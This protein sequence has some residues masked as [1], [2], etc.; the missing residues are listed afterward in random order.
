MCTLDNHVKL[1]TEVLLKANSV[2]VPLLVW[3][4]LDKYTNK[5]TQLSNYLESVD[6]ETLTE[7]QKKALD[8]A[9]EKMQICVNQL[10]ASIKDLTDPIAIKR[11]GKMSVYNRVADA[12]SNYWHACK[13]ELLDCFFQELFIHE[14]SW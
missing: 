12:V 13:G 7:E 4:R 10:N 9:F 8:S 11:Y 2:C 6:S 3:K 5:I 1:H 14:L